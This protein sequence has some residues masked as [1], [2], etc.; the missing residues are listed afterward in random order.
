MWIQKHAAQKWHHVIL[1]LEPLSLTVKE[2]GKLKMKF[3]A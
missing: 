1:G 2:K 3:L